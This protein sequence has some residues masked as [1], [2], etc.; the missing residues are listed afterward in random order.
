MLRECPYAYYVHY[1]AHQLQL[2]L[3]AASREIHDVHTFFQNTNLIIN[4]VSVSPKPNDELL[5]NQIAEIVRNIDLRELDT[6][7]GANQ[8]GSLQ[9]PGDTRRSSH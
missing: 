5:T 4:I 3:I 2:V 9:R 6:G 1:M 7:R 8:I